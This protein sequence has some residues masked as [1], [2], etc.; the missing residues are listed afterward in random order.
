MRPKDLQSGIRDNYHRGTIG[1]FLK[2]KIKDGSHLSVVS[3]YFT[4]YAFEALKDKLWGIDRLD[5]MIAQAHAW[6]DRLLERSG[7]LKTDAP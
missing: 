2:Q 4:I 6:S 3:T 1:D 5:E 7:L